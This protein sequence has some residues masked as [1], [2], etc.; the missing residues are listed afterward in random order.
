[1][2]L[3]IIQSS[4]FCYLFRSLY[5]TGPPLIEQIDLSDVVSFLRK[6]YNVE[7]II[8]FNSCKIHKKARRKV[9][10]DA[11]PPVQEDLGKGSSKE[12][13]RMRKSVNRFL[14]KLSLVDSNSTENKHR[15]F[16]VVEFAVVGDIV[17]VSNIN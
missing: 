13:R 12:D 17:V 10:K 15:S 2:H 1:M 3:Y 5:G 4:Q 16:Q 11:P 7:A 14:K 9:K 8:L 6:K